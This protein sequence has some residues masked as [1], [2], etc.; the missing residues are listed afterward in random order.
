MILIQLWIEFVMDGV[1]QDRVCCGPRCPE[2]DADSITI[3][4]HRGRVCYGTSPGIPL[5]ICSK[6]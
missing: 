2:T 5:I 3:K 6:R 1:C 4:L